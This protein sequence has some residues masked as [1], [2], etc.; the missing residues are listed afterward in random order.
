[1]K[2]TVENQIK[3]MLENHTKNVK[4]LFMKKA[5]IYQP[6]KNAM[7][8]GK[9]KTNAWL[10]EFVPE[11]PYFV[12]GLMGWSG[13]D[14]TTRELSLRFPSKETAIAYATKKNIEFEV[15]LPNKGKERRKAYADNF[16]YSKVNT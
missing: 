5:R 13:M 10:L 7:Q 3:N 16:T 14:D 9:G 15:V 11:T 6:T 2:N 8:S 4:R 1:M 12:E